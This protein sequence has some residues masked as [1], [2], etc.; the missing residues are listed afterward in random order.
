MFYGAVSDDTRIRAAMP[1]IREL[2]DKGAIVL[3]LSHFGRQRGAKNPPQ[4]L[5]LVMGGL[6]DV[7]G[8]SVLFIPD[9]IGVGAKAGVAVLAAA[10]VAVLANARIHPLEPT[11]D[12]AFAVPLD[13]LGEHSCNYPPAPPHPPPGSPESTA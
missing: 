1:T 11:N 10:E 3:L 12:P 8:H 6:E 7:L 4:S 5:S 2:S 13:A 9:C